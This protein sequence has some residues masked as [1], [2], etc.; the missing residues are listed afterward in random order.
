MVFF[1]LRAIDWIVPDVPGSLE[2]KMK[3]ER[4]LAKQALAENQEALLVSRGQWASS[5][6]PGASSTGQWNTGHTHSQHT[7]LA[8][9]FLNQR[10]NNQIQKSC[11]KMNPLTSNIVHRFPNNM[12]LFSHNHNLK[13]FSHYCCHDSVSLLHR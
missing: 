1:V 3:R 4:Y 12:Q 13:I 8:F 9:V 5:A 7:R 10:S 6:T 11:F 2:L